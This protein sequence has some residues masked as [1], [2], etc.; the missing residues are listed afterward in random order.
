[1]RK[2]QKEKY[3]ILSLAILTCFLFVYLVIFPLWGNLKNV[4]RSFSAQ[5]RAEKLFNAR[6]SD[7]SLFKVKESTYSSTFRQL[8]NFFVSSPPVEFIRFLEKEAEETGVEAKILSGKSNLEK[9]QLWKSLNFTLY[10]N[11]PYSNFAKFL[12]RLEHSPYFLEMSQINIERIT[13]ENIKRKNWKEASEGDVYAFL[14]L[15]VFLKKP[16]N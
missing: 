15:K 6:L 11:S 9:F 10:V 13:E 5:K 14:K 1:M 4:S 8:D 7:F 12:K 3:L 2:E 16:I